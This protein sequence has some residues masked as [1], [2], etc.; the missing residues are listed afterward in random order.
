MEVKEVIP[1]AQMRL[2]TEPGEI[3]EHGR[4]QGQPAP[5]GACCISTPEEVEESQRIE[6]MADFIA[7][8][9]DV[10]RA[11]GA[12]DIVYW[13]YW[14][15]LQGNMKFHPRELKKIADLA[16]PLCIDYIQESQD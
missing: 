6:W 16:I 10:F 8:Y 11:A 4:F 12:S 5:H 3:Q 2:V 14:T 7:R 15:G 1:N 9:S 13:L